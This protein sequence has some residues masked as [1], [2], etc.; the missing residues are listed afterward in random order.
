LL[1][2]AA[3]IGGEYGITVYDAAYVAASRRHRWALVSTDMSD[4]VSP[5]LAVLPDRIEVDG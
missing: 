5:G 4:L 1:A 2:D 3:G